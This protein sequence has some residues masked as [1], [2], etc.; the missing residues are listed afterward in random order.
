MQLSGGFNCFSSYVN[1]VA[2]H[3]IPNRFC[4]CAF[5]RVRARF[6]LRI[7]THSHLSCH[8]FF[9]RCTVSKRVCV[10]CRWMCEN[11]SAKILSPAGNEFNVFLSLSLSLIPLYVVLC[12]KINFSLCSLVLADTL[13]LHEI[14]SVQKRCIWT[15]AYTVYSIS[16]T[17]CTFYFTTQLITSDKSHLNEQR[18]GME[19]A[20]AIETLNIVIGGLISF[21]LSNR[22]LRC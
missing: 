11:G 9:F 7:F 20:F 3:Q 6:A 13:F 2:A 17:I 14:Y 21:L 5:A 1:I 16:K 15:N 22:M 12:A 8:T 10:W 18:R 19:E 4:M